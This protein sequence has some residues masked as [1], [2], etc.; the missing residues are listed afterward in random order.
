[1]FKTCRGRLNYVKFL[2]GTA[3]YW[4]CI[5]FTSH[6]C[7]SIFQFC[8]TVSNAWLQSV[9]KWDRVRTCLQTEL[10]LLS[11]F[12]WWLEGILPW[13]D[14][15]QTSQQTSFLQGLFS[16]FN[17]RYFL[18]KFKRKSDWI[19]KLLLNCLLNPRTYKGGGGG[20]NVLSI[21][22]FWVFFFLEDKTLPPHVFSSCLFISRADF[23][24]S[25]EMISS[26]GYKIWRHK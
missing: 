16:V 7:W 25:L 4:P 6:R 15:G 2:S 1:M 10:R 12:V 19:F 26:Y 24:T 18:F 20:G 8:S 23:E 13:E 9:Y 3:Q 14:E 21:R 5:S 22:F 17:P 11:S